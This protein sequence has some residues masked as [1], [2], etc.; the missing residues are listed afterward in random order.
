MK[1]S[2]D[3]D[4]HLKVK[5]GSLTGR[6]RAVQYNLWVPLRTLEAICNKN[7]AAKLNN[8]GHDL[9]A[10]ESPRGLRRLSNRFGKVVNISSPLLKIYLSAVTK[11]PTYFKS[12]MDADDLYTIEF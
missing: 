10:F 7:V 9:C 11:L 2:M 3:T 12:Y 5:N 6:W 4:L 1:C 8:C